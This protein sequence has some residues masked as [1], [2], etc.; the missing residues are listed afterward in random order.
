MTELDKELIRVYA[1]LTPEEKKR[2]D[3][4]A[5]KIKRERTDKK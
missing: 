4:Y 5:E 2:V 1:S 3:A